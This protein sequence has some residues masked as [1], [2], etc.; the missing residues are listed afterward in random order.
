MVNNGGGLF[1]STNLQIVR[2]E[3]EIRITNN[4]QQFSEGLVKSKITN[5]SFFV[6]NRILQKF[7]AN[8]G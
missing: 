2:N 4:L 5:N 8:C 3:V 7:L 6:N 1:S